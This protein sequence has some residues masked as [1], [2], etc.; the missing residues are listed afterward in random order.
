MHKYFFV[1]GRNFDLSKTEII[2]LLNILNFN[3]KII[4]ISK[5]VLIIETAEKMDAENLLKTLGGTIK[6][7]EIL[8]NYP[9]DEF[10]KNYKTLL[11]D[12]NLLS[13]LFDPSLQKLTFG[14]SFYK[15]DTAENINQIYPP[16]MKLL[17]EIK[18]FLGQSYKVNFFKSHERYISS[19]SV[20]KNKLL[21][22]GFELIIIT[23]EKEV[24]LGKTLSVQDFEDYSFRDYQRP[25]RDMNEGIMPPK[26]A[27]IMINLSGADKNQAILDPFCGNGTI[28]QELILLGF[29]NIIG[30]DFSKDQVLKT[31]ENIDWLFEKYQ[32]LK[33]QEFN[34]KIFESDVKILK[35]KVAENSIDAIITE[36]FLGS[37][38]LKHF[39]PERVEEEIRTLEKLYFSA[40]LEFKKILKSDGKIVIIFPVFKSGGKEHFLNILPQIL[41]LGFSIKDLQSE[42]T[43]RGS[44]IYSRPNQLVNREIF[45]YEKYHLL[46][47]PGLE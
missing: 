30:S 19:V 31:I 23:T 36:P 39:S 6:I 47:E 12:I 10:I 25:E 2:T 11:I 41:R 15:N 7:G 40:F 21:T 46:F 17:P 8:E 29:K 44:I 28:I 32:N 43:P 45:V 24:F 35:N 1:L 20:N 33:K 9:T 37:S 42:V 27:K 3:P 38:N 18:H 14:F 16:I 4:L 26:L 13:Q 22:D 5:E 34:I